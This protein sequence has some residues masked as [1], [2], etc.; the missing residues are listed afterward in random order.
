MG[1]FMKL[2]K[3]TRWQLVLAAVVAAMLFTPSAHSQEIT[4]TAFDDGPY[5]TGFAQPTTAQPYAQ[6]VPAQAAVPSVNEVAAIQASLSTPRAASMDSPLLTAG[7]TLL[8]FIGIALAAI[9]ELKR[10]NRDSLSGR[11]YASPRGA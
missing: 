10:T 5:V 11:R 2:R 9:R 4:N 6:T 3:M 1:C 8:L 7:L